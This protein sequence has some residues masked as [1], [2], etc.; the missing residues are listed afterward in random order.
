MKHSERLEVFEILRLLMVE[1]QLWRDFE[2]N[3]CLSLPSDVADLQIFLL[4]FPYNNSVLCSPVS[5]SLS[6]TLII[7]KISEN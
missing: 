5:L 3:G 2:L 7:E 1:S 4:T 6:S